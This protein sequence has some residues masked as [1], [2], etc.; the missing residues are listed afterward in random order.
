LVDEPGELFGFVL[1]IFEAKTD[2][3]GVEVELRTEVSAG[4]NILDG[5]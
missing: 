3:D 4:N 2:R 1:D 5:D